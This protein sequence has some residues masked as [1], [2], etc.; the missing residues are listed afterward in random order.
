MDRRSFLK[1]VGAIFVLGACNS[2]NA[3][4]FKR[5]NSITLERLKEEAVGYDH[6]VADSD[7]EIKKYKGKGLKPIFEHLKKD[8]FKNCFV[9]DKLTGKASALLLAYGKAKKLYTRTLSR[10]A[11]PILEKYNIE[12]EVE[13]L[14]D[15]IINWSKTDKCPMEKAVENTD[16][17]QSA[18]KI[19]KSKFQ[20]LS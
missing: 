13:I 9:Y 18:Y 1:A 6:V 16:N 19:L 5:E 17:P 7:G 20:D 15:Y 14:T 2:A 10:E 8:N 12:Y 11:L 3:F 4:S